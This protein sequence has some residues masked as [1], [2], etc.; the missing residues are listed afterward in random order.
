[1][2]QKE[3][4]SAT[5]RRF[6]FICSHVVFYHCM[7]LITQTSAVPDPGRRLAAVCAECSAGNEN[8]QA[9]SVNRKH[10]YR[11]DG[12]GE[13]ALFPSSGCVEEL[14]DPALG[15]MLINP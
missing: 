1:M 9:S 12:C 11:A 8:V 10:S 13:P 6:C 4:R 7:A 2:S 15:R 5:Q 14:Q 3:G